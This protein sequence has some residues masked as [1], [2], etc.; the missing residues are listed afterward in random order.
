M[1]QV[2]L[3]VD[4]PRAQPC[5]DLVGPEA[6]RLRIRRPP[7][8]YSRNDRKDNIAPD[9]RGGATAVTNARNHS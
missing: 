6:V 9:I 7:A 8:A 1:A 5:L 2:H 3:V 4:L